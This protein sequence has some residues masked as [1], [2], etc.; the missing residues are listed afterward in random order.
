MKVQITGGEGFI[1][2]HTADRLLQKGYD[3]QVLDSLEVPV[4]KTKPE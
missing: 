3:V 2:S 4:H 1:E